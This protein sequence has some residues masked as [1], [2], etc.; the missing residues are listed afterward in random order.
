[1]IELVG[2]S[3]IEQKAVRFSGIAFSDICRF[4]IGYCTFITLACVLDPMLNLGKYKEAKGA[5]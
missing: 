3:L 1:M 4:C 2:V 5:R